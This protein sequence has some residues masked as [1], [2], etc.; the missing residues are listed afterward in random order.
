MDAVGSKFANTDEQSIEVP[1]LEEGRKLGYRIVKRAFDI[2][3]SLIGIPFFCVD[4]YSDCYWYC[5]GRWLSDFL[6][7]GKNRIKRNIF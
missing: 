4:N 5:I 7:S 3:F 1:S 2:F 6:C